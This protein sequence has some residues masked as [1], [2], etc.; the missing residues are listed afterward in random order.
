MSRNYRRQWNGLV[1]QQM[2]DG[3]WRFI[4]STN[5]TRTWAGLVFQQMPDALLHERNNIS[6]C[7]E[8]PWHSTSKAVLGKHVEKQWLVFYNEHTEEQNRTERLPFHCHCVI[9]CKWNILETLKIHLMVSF[10][11]HG[12]FPGWNGAHAKHGL[13]SKHRTSFQSFVHGVSFLSDIAFDR[14]FGYATKHLNHILLHG[15]FK[16]IFFN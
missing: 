16:K 12:V 1:C 2:M 10:F 15:V 8:W 4:I 13:N 3:N 6:F 5:V 14:H 9:Q 7:H 11:N